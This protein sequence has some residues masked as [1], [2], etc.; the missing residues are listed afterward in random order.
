M[1]APTSLEG[2]RPKSMLKQDFAQLTNHIQHQLAEAGR[3][4]NPISAMFDSLAHP[5]LDT[6]RG[7]YPSFLQWK[8]PVFPH[9]LNENTKACTNS[10]PP[11]PTFKRVTTTTAQDATTAQSTTARSHMVLGRGAV[12]GIWADM[13]QDHNQTL[14]YNEHME[15]P[16]YPFSKFMDEHPE[17]DQD[18]ERPL[19]SAVSAYY[20]TYV[21]RMEI[22]SNFSEY[23]TV[24]GI[25]HL[26]DL[27]GHCCCA[28][29]PQMDSV[30]RMD[31]GQ[32]NQRRQR[33][34]LGPCSSCSRY[35]YAV[36]GHID[37]HSSP[38]TTAGGGGGRGGKRRRVKFLMRC[39]TVILATG[40]FDQP[41][42]LQAVS[43]HP[44]LP[45]PSSPST[46]TIQQ[47]FHDTRQLEEWMKR[48]DGYT[49]GHPT[50][51]AV[52]PP[53]SPSPS[54][55]DA[56]SSSPSPPANSASSIGSPSMSKS[57]L[58]KPPQTTPRPIVIVGTG[59][60][61]A[62]AILLIQEKQPWRRVIHIYKHFTSSEPSP[63]KRCHRD[64]YPEYASIWMRMRKCATLKN[65]VQCYQKPVVGP[66]G[67]P[68]CTPQIFG[69]LA[70]ATTNCEQCKL[71]QA[72]STKNEQIEDRECSKEGIVKD[73]E[74]LAK[75]PLPLCSACSYRG[76]PDASV[77][78]WNPLTGEIVI[79]L[80]HGVVIKEMVAA[81]GV[82]IGKEVHMGFLKGS[83]AEE[84]LSTPEDSDFSGG[85]AT[86][87]SPPTM[88]ASTFDANP[89][90]RRRLGGS[91]TRRRRGSAD[92]RDL[93]VNM[94]TPPCTPPR[95]PQLRPKEKKSF[96][97]NPCQLLQDA[98]ED[99]VLDPEVHTLV[100]IQGSVKE[101]AAEIEACTENETVDL[102]GE[103]EGS[104]EESSESDESSEEE[105]VEQHQVLTLL[106]PLVSDMYN[107]RIIPS[108][109]ASVQGSGSRMPLNDHAAGGPSPASSSG[110]ATPLGSA[111]AYPTKVKKCTRLPCYPIRTS[112]CSSTTTKSTLQLPSDETCTPALSS[113]VAGSFTE[114]AAAKDSSLD[115]AEE[116]LEVESPL[117]GKAKSILSKK[118]ACLSMPCSPLLRSC[119]TVCPSIAAP[120]LL[121][122]CSAAATSAL[123][124][125][126]QTLTAATR[127][128]PSS[129]SGDVD[130]T[131]EATEEEV[132]QPP[133]SASASTCSLS[134]SLSSNSKSGKSSCAS[135]VCSM[136]LG[137]LKDEHGEDN[138]ADMM[139]SADECDDDDDEYEDAQ[140][141]DCEGNLLVAPSC[142]PSLYPR[143]DQSIYAAGAITG[144][145]FV[146]YVLGNGIAVVADILKHEELEANM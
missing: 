57:S 73:D 98:L 62:D 5:H 45:P 64:V 129:S 17:Y 140:E 99:K 116:Q 134:L 41:K 110:M 77:S 27:P 31:I 48:H 108:H 126:L 19:R 89:S 51:S 84:M 127:R 68:T 80:S 83:L 30:T 40:T 92:S 141:V 90:L 36:L 4:A 138:D 136:P 50:V 109:V 53:P 105:K 7:E 128:S 78:S 119:R 14:S 71:V 118:S 49:Q 12:G 22:Q 97:M 94:L 91:T 56:T 58:T 111:V 66:D 1:L 21:Q 54:S 101:K 46:M 2:C 60:S 121:T 67:V 139:Y 96:W 29:D 86:Y 124:N 28:L 44:C 15:L 117:S 115:F 137:D 143:M 93:A 55:D 23:T 8:H 112:E 81:V 34:G 32:E 20:K 13:E 144:S 85:A 6:H 18:L 120:P 132:S 26:K 65:S 130:R 42:K 43:L 104:K 100:E 75:A 145:K 47:T 63:L 103:S 16:L 52:S 9:S 25:F 39:K 102:S 133:L 24:T 69:D 87:S 59:L 38:S 107:F 76:L 72:E 131:K 74:C 135:S 11:T 79:I 3:D 142:T 125:C 106:R 123:T 95:S 88:A 70:S 82:F 61:A 35:R 33:L 37:S 113:T 10:P 122:L 114:S 146:R